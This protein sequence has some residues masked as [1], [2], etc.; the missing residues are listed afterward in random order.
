[1]WAWIG[2]GLA[3]LGTA[4]A[5]VYRRRPAASAVASEIY[6]MTARSHGRFAAVS[7]AFAAGFLVLAFVRVVPPL[8]F[9]AV[10]VLIAVLYATSFARGFSEG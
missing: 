1:M 6:G 7:G 3:T 2:A 8:P 9:V 10:Y 5:L 4:V